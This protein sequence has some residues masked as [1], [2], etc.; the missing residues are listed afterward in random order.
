MYKIFYLPLIFVLFYSCTTYL[1]YSA[2][3]RPKSITD[4]PIKGPSENVDCFFNNQMPSRAFYKVNIVEVTGAANASYDELLISLKNNAKVSGYDALLV[5]DKQQEVAYQN[6]RAVNSMQLVNPYQKLSAIGVKYAQNINYLDSII[7]STRFNFTGESIKGD[8]E[9]HFDFYGN[10]LLNNAAAI[11]NYF[12]D[13]IEPFDIEKHLQGTVKDWSYA[14]NSILPEQVIAFKKEVGDFIQ[15]SVNAD[16]A[17]ADKFYYKILNQANNKTYKYI[18]KVEHDNAG[19]I[20]KKTLFQKNKILWM[21]EVY[22]NKNIVTGSKRFRFN[23][24]NN[25]IIFSAANSFYSV[26]DLPEPLK[27]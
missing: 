5:L 26:K 15:V 7:K 20:T 4:I 27:Y 14:R 21:E 25:E 6:Y 12:I 24:G 16:Q 10:A 22:Y 2:A 19:R 1:P 9:I 11:N 17:D 13:S 8:T 18:L 3:S 23:N